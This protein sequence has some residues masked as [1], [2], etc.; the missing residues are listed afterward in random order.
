M[1]NSLPMFEQKPWFSEGLRF[2]CTGC[3]QCC[4]GSP[5]YVWVSDEEIAEMASHLN[6]SVPLFR[7][8]YLRKVGDRESLLEHP[9]TFDCVFLKDNKCRI[10]SVRPK[11][12]RTFPWWKHNLESKAQW[13]AAASYCEGINHPDAPLFSSEEILENS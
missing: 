9:R 12:C 8:N 4:T 5:G 3:G 11:Q 6:I 13:D 1:S 10:Y 2:K 7:Q